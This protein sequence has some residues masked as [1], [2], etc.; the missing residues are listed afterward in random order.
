M[1]FTKY[2]RTISLA[3]SLT[4]LVGCNKSA[5]PESQVSVVAT[6]GSVS[7]TVDDLKE[8]FDKLAASSK[9]SIAEDET[10]QKRFLNDE[11][12]K[13]VL[14]Q[15][16]IDKGMMEDAKVQDVIRKTLLTKM[17]NEAVRQMKSTPEPTDEQIEKY[18]KENIRD[19]VHPEEYRFKYVRIPFNE[20]N[21]PKMKLLAEKVKAFAKDSKTLD[22]GLKLAKVT[23][24]ESQDSGYVD[25]VLALTLLGPRGQ[26]EMWKTKRKGVIPVVEVNGAYIVAQRYGKKASKNESLADARKRIEGKIKLLER[27]RIFKEYVDNTPTGRK[28]V[29]LEENLPTLSKRL[30]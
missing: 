2:F 17:T 6:V 25:K 26:N 23:S 5:A 22:R 10:R 11:I 19:Y 27:Q 14:I 13:E 29:I 30:N 20:S 18:Y 4:I 21:K 24:Y 3:V 7:I 8:R 28:V 9:K 1:S 15:E 12:R 16:A